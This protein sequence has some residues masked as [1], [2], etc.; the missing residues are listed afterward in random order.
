[1]QAARTLARTTRKPQAKTRPPALIL[2]RAALWGVLASLGLVVLYAVALR[3]VKTPHKLLRPI[4][5]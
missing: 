2:L 3:Q 1:M 4:Q 5:H